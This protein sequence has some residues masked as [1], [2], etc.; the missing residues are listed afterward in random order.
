MV[1][2]I[3]NKQSWL[4]LINIDSVYSSDKQRQAFSLFTMIAISIVVISILIFLNYDVYSPILT[5]ALIAVNVTIICSMFYFIKTGELETVA[6]ICMSIVFILCIVLTYTGGKENTALYWL[7]FYPVVT[8]SSLGVRL[9]TWLGLTLLLCCIAILYGPNFGQVVYGDIEK[10]R[11]IA[12]FT[13]VYIFSFIGEFFRY[14]SHMAIA[15]ITLEQKQDAY[16][17]QLTG[18]ANRRFITSHFLKLV[19]SRPNEYLP[20]SLLLLDLDHFKRLN[21]T[22]GHDFGDIVLIEFTKILESQ[23]PTSAVKARYGGEEFVVILPKETSANAV[24]IANRFREHVA[25]QVLLAED[26]L[27]ISLTCSIGV[28]QVDKVGDY[29]SALKQADEYLYNAKALGRNKV[30]STKD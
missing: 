24:D 12:S 16:T 26:N 18:I 4:N 22:Y 30:V 2:K 13:L 11:F 8:F 25:A 20:F 3:S 29:N 14:R 23:F 17:D 7:M 9:G 28:V 6:L 1:N 19:D 21:D 15:D 5:S 10:T 27:Q